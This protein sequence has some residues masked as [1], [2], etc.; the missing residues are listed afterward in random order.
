MKIQNLNGIGL[1]AVF[2]F[3]TFVIPCYAVTNPPAEFTINPKVI[4]KAP[5][6]FGFN[7][8][9]S[10]SNSFDITDNALI[11]DGAFSSYDVRFDYTATEDG[12]PDGTTFIANNTKANGARYGTDFY[13]S[14]TSNGC[15]N[16]ASVRVYRFDT[17]NSGWQ[18]VR[19]GTIKSMTA[20]ADSKQ[21][22]DH[23][24]TFTT[25]GAQ[26]LGGDAMW[27]ARD[28]IYDSPDITQWVNF[29]DDRFQIY[30]LQWT[31]IGEK[32]FARNDPNPCTFVH[33]TDV[34][35]GQ[36]N[37]KS[38]VPP[39]SIKI[40][41]TATSGAAGIYKFAP[42]DFE[43]GHQY[44]VTVWLKQT[45]I[46]SGNV[47]LNLGSLT[48]V[49]ENVTNQWQQFTYTFPTPPSIKG[50]AVM[51]LFYSAPGTLWVNQIQMFDTSHKPFTL[52]PRVLQ[53]FKDFN[54]GVIRIWSGFGDSGMGYSYW[55]LD[56]WLQEDSTSRGTP[57]I[58][59]VAYRIS[60]PWKLASSLALC[61]QLGADPWL[62]CEMC[63]S[64]QEWSDFIDYLAAP[65][66]KG[67][68]VK[69]PADHP[70]PY[71]Q[72]FDKIYVEFGN[73]EWGTQKT[74][75][76]GHYGEYA[77]LMF[78]QAIAGKS[79]FD[80][81]KIKLILNN[82]TANPGFGD[83]ALAVCP[84]AQGLDYFLYTGNGKLHGDEKYQ[85]DLLSISDY[86]PRIDKWVAEEAKSAAHG[87]PYELTCYEGGNGSDDPTSKGE[88]DVTL[89]AATGQLDVFLYAQQTGMTALNFFGYRLGSRL[90]SSHST[91][92]NGFIP[93]PIW[94]ALTL[95]NQ[96]CAGD[97]VASTAT[98]CP[99]STDPKKT[100]LIGVYTFHET[101][102]G[103]H[104]ADIV[105]VSR[106]LNNETP[107]T[108]NLP[109]AATGEATLY[110]LTGDPRASNATSLTIPI[111][112]K[113]IPNFGKSYQFN[114]PAGSTFLFQVPT[115]PWP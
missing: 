108:L 6:R 104:Q 113:S 12:A 41:T 83:K 38:D 14:L 87:R 96:Y 2:T 51:Q 32:G 111:V 64:E 52:D 11:A 43:Q 109:V 29:I 77:H 112:K 76:N 75:V 15:F 98:T 79:Y 47:T 26:C 91:F 82:F 5:M 105:V 28:G 67:Y 35:P 8:G 90:Y 84:E 31:A 68:A 25:P 88:G 10:T 16:G 33:V 59:A 97:M 89:A 9:Q 45:G 78:S 93:H 54:P 44:A 18:L 42:K 23:T 86:K 103:K 101:S 21:P 92:A 85:N 4:S 94:Q 3:L 80:P 34:P 22:E 55:S 46:V 20:I 62:I 57:A 99:V 61:K 107:V 27:L 24:I 72:D 39:L 53:S 56:S 110:T 81:T 74:A 48:H 106:D 95:R 17:K 19:T 63:W 1:L 36:T 7:F 115:G 70:G 40:T 58:G 13:R 73:E 37:G 49:F 69:R 102:G 71:T 50:G 30:T 66:G 65:A 60:Q 100:P 114:M